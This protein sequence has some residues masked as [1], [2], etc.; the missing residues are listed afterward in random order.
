MD[1]QLRPRS[2][3]EILD[4]T[5]K[6]YRDHAAVLLGISAPMV[7]LNAPSWLLLH[8]V[9]E[10][11]GWLVLVPALVFAMLAQFL[12][13]GALIVATTDAYLGRTI[14]VRA[15][16]ARA[17]DQVGSLL[18]AGSLFALGVA[19]GLVLLLIPGFYLLL[20]WALWTP[21]LFVEGRRGGEALARSAQLV[22]GAMGRLSLLLLAFGLL[23]FTLD[24]GLRALLPNV[25]GDL[26]WL[27]ALAAGV[28]AALLAPLN[29]AL[30]TLF[31][32]DGRIRHEGFDL[33]LRAGQPLAPAEP[34]LPR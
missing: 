24:A 30:L 6:L 5:F 3:S 19:G 18:W 12:V 2:V 31:Y 29:P 22:R 23:Q 17:F 21:A 7:L 27:S 13:V 15:A 10:G 28:P 9:K 14:S 32:F 1:N 33:E 26:P 4:G 8:H 11:G 20:R 34:G 16:Y 25:L